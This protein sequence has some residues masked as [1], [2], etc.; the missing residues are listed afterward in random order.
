MYKKNIWGNVLWILHKPIED[1]D[2]QSAIKRF[3]RAVYRQGLYLNTKDNTGRNVNSVQVDYIYS[4]GNYT[5][6]HLDNGFTCNR[7]RKRLYEWEEELKPHDFVRIS[8]DYIVNLY[9]VKNLYKKNENGN[10]KYS[11]K[12]L[13]NEFLKISEKYS[14]NFV[15]KRTDYLI[16]MARK[17]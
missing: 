13:G 14:D 17:I 10:K 7:D 8:R 12:T 1:T 6:V 5:F 4:K 11:I 15:E 2:L 16:K 3:F 9:Y